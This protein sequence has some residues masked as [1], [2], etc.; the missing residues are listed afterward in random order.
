[1]KQYRHLFAMLS[2]G[3]IS[4]CATP[5]ADSDS[6][7]AV[8]QFDEIV[9]DPLAHSGK[10]FCGE[11]FAV[12]SERTVRILAKP[13]EMPPSDDLAFL[14]TIKSRAV[15]AG[16]SEIPSKF[17]LEATIDPQEQ[18]FLPSGSGEDCSPFRRP[19]LIH[20][21]RAEPRP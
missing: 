18:C 19:V 4:A 12:V 3:L 16:L 7:C 10:V 13:D 11:A 2:F 15:L 17:Y 14:V 21:L 5:A 6:R 1:V 8:S 20:V 9:R